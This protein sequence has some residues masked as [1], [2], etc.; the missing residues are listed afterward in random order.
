SSRPNDSNHS[1]GS[2]SPDH[3]W[4]PALFQLLEFQLPGDVLGL[5]LRQCRRL[6]AILLL[7]LDHF[8]SPR[9]RMGP[10]ARSQKRQGPFTHRT[11]QVKTAAVPA[12]RT[13][14]EEKRTRKMKHSASVGR[15][16]PRK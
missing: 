5:R 15:G 7:L 3:A 4:G 6:G 9:P 10:S 13:R 2:V 12:V 14:N 1:R 11:P 16:D 8:T